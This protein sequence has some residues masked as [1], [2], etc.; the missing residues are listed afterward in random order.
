MMGKGKG[1]RKNAEIQGQEA[2][3]ERIPFFVTRLLKTVVDYESGGWKERC[4]F[5]Y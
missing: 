4:I 3:Q 2:L 1:F 5:D